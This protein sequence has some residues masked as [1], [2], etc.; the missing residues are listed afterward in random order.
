M[1]SI[2]VHAGS[3][4]MP[5]DGPGGESL[6]ATRTGPDRAILANVPFFT[7]GL[8]IFDLVK[9]D[10]ENEILMVYD[11]GGQKNL[12][13]IIIESDEGG[14]FKKV[15]DDLERDFSARVEGG[16]GAL[17]AVS[18]PPTLVKMVTDYF[19]ENSIAWE[20]GN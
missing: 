3:K 1:E 4:W 7:Q 8:N 18:V 15:I 6:W 17:L 19:D 2:K 10:S 9:I 12:R 20:N 5:E 16:F 14:E 13:A 11:N